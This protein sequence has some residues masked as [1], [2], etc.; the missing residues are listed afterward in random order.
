MTQDFHT[1][2]RLVQISYLDTYIFVHFAQNQKIWKSYSAK[3]Q[4]QNIV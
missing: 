4:N 3:Q 1:Q 2:D